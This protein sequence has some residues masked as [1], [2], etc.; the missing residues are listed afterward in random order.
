M[1]RA[2]FQINEGGKNSTIPQTGAIKEV[3]REDRLVTNIDLS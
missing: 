2:A 3:N 1:L